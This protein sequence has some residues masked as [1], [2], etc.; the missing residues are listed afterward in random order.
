VL[1]RDRG[2]PEATCIVLDVLD[3]SGD[4]RAGFPA[5]IIALRQLTFE[6]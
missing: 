2:I 1:L 5:E 6:K 3:P 4:F